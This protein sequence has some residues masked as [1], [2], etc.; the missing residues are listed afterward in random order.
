MN[1]DKTLSVPKSPYRGIRPFRFIDQ[2]YFFGR[3]DIVTALLAKVLV[4][5]LVLLFGESGAGKSSLLNAG[6]IPALR[7]EG[8]NPERI[9]L[10]PDQEEPFQAE[11]ILTGKSEGDPFLPSIFVQAEIGGHDPGEESVSLSLDQLLESV[12]ETD[13]HP[14]LIFDQFEELFTLFG[15]EVQ[16][17]HREPNLRNKILDAIYRIVNDTRLRVKVIIT[18][19]EDFLGKLEVLAKRYPR[20][21]DYRVRLEHLDQA[22]ARKAILGPFEEA[23]PFR[24]RLTPALAD[25]IIQDLPRDQPGESIQA[26]QVQIVCERLWENFA[27]RKD[28]IS[29]DEYRALNGVKGIIERYLD[30]ELEHFDESLKTLAVEILSH[31]IT[32]AGTRDVVSEDH[33][34][35]SIGVE[36]GSR[37]L[38]EA[39]DI[40]KYL[41]NRR[42]IYKT[43][44]RG[45]F[46]YELSNEYLIKRIQQL[47]LIQER[48]RVAQ[49]T[50]AK[51]LVRVAWIIIA[52]SA[53]AGLY[54]LYKANQEKNLLLQQLEVVKK[55]RQTSDAAL[56]QATRSLGAAASSLA[57]AGRE[58]D[59]AAKARQ[60]AEAYSHVVEDERDTATSNLLAKQ[61]QDNLE[62]DSQLSIL[63]ALEAYRRD[64][65]TQAEDVLRRALK[66]PSQAV[67][68][69][70]ARTASGG[71]EARN[72]AL[73]VKALAISPDGQ[74]IATGGADGIG[75]IWDFNTRQLKA[76]LVGHEGGVFGVAF[77]PDGLWLAT[78]GGDQ[79]VRLWDVSTAVATGGTEGLKVSL[80]GHEGRVSGLAFS[81]DGKILASNSEDLSTRLW[82]ISRALQ[83]GSEEA[84]VAVLQGHGDLLNGLA[85]SQDGHWLATASKDGTIGLWDVSTALETGTMGSQ[86][87][88]INNNRIPV[89]N[90]AFSP[91]D[92]MLASAGEDGI[93]RL[94]D[95]LPALE[96]NGA[97]VILSEWKAHEGPAFG[98]NFSPDG[99]MLAT[100]GADGTSRLWNIGPG[101]SSEQVSLFRGQ[102]GE[103]F[104]IAVHP[105]NGTLVSLGRD[106]TVRIWQAE[107]SGAQTVLRGHGQLVYDVA[108]SPDGKYLATNGDDLTTRLWDVGKALKSGGFDA[109]LAELS[110]YEGVPNGVAFS[111]SGSWLASASAD[112]NVR[113]WNVEEAVQTGG[114]DAQPIMLQGHSDDVYKVAF[115]PD[116][117]ILATA[118]SDATI[119]LWDVSKPSETPS[120]NFQKAILRGHEGEVFDL[121]FS[122]DGHI[123]AS[124]GT[125]LTT[126]LWDV[127]AALEAGGGDVQVAEMRG[128][129]ADL[130]S[131]SYSQD[132]RWLATASWDGTVVL[133]DVGPAIQSGGNPRQLATL[134]V[135]E[136]LINRVAF[137]PDGKILAI[138]GED[139]TIRLMDVAGVL[140]AQGSEGQLAVL[141]GHSGSVYGLDFSPH[142]E[143][144]ATSSEDGTARLWIV[145]IEQLLE[146]ACNVTS[147][148]LTWSEWQNYIGDKSYQRTCEN[149]PVHT[150]VIQAWVTQ[151]KINEALDALR[152]A[153]KIDPGFVSEPEEELARLLIEQGRRYVQSGATEQAEKILGQAIEFDDSFLEEAATILADLGSNLAQ[154]GDY[155][156]AL[157]ILNESL[158]WDP[159]LSLVPQAV[160]AL[161][162]G[163]EQARL[164][165]DSALNP[166]QEAA[167]LDPDLKPEVAEILIDLAGDLAFRGEYRKALAVLQRVIDLGP[168]IESSRRTVLA[169]AYVDVCD[170]ASLDGMANTA[171]SACQRAVDLAIKTD[172]AS[173]NNHICWFGSI[174]GYAE[175]V[176]P[177]CERAVQLGNQ[178]SSSGLFH[179]R[180][181]RGL[182]RALTDDFSGAIDD[183][184]FYVEKAAGEEAGTFEDR[185]HQRQSWIAD[186]EAGDNPFDESTLAKLRNQG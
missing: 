103:V 174:D 130:S 98:L 121:A 31:L 84:T 151:G 109:Q 146:Q 142:G 91:A 186:L 182:A 61:S 89:N 32:E 112:D 11:R 145:G 148:N 63:L 33:L 65:T 178:L 106:N 59:A 107:G 42:V 72:F 8:L 143:Y 114:D 78:S 154:Q 69:I 83:T 139:G 161:A 27:D 171:E 52:V 64:H 74:M 181:S 23:N 164:G 44:R 57:L 110:G 1:K 43:E 138:A 127:P 14:V 104:S 166:L 3:E 62:G 153:K 6:L 46:Y 160:V 90:V 35:R 19:R 117:K 88:I 30:S 158:E 105:T 95:V 66:S 167:E 54:F 75:R 38:A 15:Y 20:V 9:R 179:Y 40:L 168:E 100:S 67:I 141:S 125:D 34:K 21:F 25:Q 24:S 68:R 157:E 86:S 140:E 93:V 116:G 126:R 173:T 184:R 132:G 152:Q 113:L 163:K 94:W 41:D 144:L 51:M 18:I 97:S 92:S 128:H 49:Q 29:L 12:Q 4:S 71:L 159:T 81:P 22:G 162:E 137:S 73:R 85:F 101:D 135:S 45:T 150:T 76:E 70:P 136:S 155:E 147:R 133:W 180:D 53:V 47:A 99:K 185:I 28:E 175:V 79:M 5:R 82:D 172:D 48:D 134:Q 16:T 119:R 118:G 50:R 111:P 17:A 183:F 129:E 37:E 26:T 122:P 7:K 77:S 169:Q 176:L 115:S 87:A 96:A 108:F 80:S 102:E 165:Q 39:T 2:D 55:A 56:A 13:T 58:R 120:G 149:I 131:L 124:N 170:F 60:T 10:K 156:R 177:A 123:L 36:E